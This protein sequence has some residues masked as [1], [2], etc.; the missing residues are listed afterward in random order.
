M[1]KTFTLIHPKMNTDRR[2]EAVKYEIKKYLKRERGK[3]LP[4]DADFWGFDCKFGSTEANAESVH[5][6]EIN[7]KID[8]VHAQAVTEFYVEIIAVAQQRTPKP[9]E[10]DAEGVQDPESE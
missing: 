8:E 10:D 4:A 6:A 3:A 1:K 9:V 7:K 2:V 5:L